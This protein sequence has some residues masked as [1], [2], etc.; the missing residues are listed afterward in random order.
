MLCCAHVYT[1]PPP[2]ICLF[3]A[4]F[5]FLKITLIVC[6]AGVIINTSCFILIISVVSF[7]GICKQTWSLVR[8]YLLKRC[9]KATFTLLVGYYYS[10]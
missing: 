9:Q 3:P 10:L 8:G 1:A 6:I 4:N 5:K 7:L 2:N